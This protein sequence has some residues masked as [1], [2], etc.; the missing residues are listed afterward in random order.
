MAWLFYPPGGCVTFVM[1]WEANLASQVCLSCCCYQVKWRKCPFSVFG[2]SIIDWFYSFRA[3]QG[4]NFGHNLS[5]EPAVYWVKLHFQ[6]D[7]CK[8][9]K[10]I[11][12]LGT[13]LRKLGL[14][15]QESNVEVIKP[16]RANPISKKKLSPFFLYFWPYVIS[17]LSPFLFMNPGGEI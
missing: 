13:S 2:Y 10:L 8:K 12:K 9:G 17:S 14:R 5:F 7:C 6:L 16:K 4:S 3:L 1:H 11:T 15:A